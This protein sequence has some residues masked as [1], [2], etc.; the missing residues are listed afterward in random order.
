MT[1]DPIG[2]TVKD[3]DPEVPPPGNGDVTVTWL[4]LL[5]VR[6]VEG[7]VALN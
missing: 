1:N 7:I 2:V 4:K 3:C 5:L 6:S